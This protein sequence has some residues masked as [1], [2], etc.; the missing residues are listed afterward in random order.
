MAAPGD[1]LRLRADLIER[2][3]VK[4]VNRPPCAPGEVCLVAGWRGAGEA[5]GLTTDAEIQALLQAVGLS[6]A[7]DETIVWWNDLWY[8]RRRGVIKALRKA[9]DI[10]DAG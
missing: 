2:G 9:A 5:A 6:W 10:L 4:W 1:R 8:R 3:E 7:H